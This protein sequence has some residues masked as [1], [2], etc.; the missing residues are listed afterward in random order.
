NGD[1]PIPVPEDLLFPQVDK[2]DPSVR[3]AVPG[4]QNEIINIQERGIWHTLQAKMAPLPQTAFEIA[5]NKDYLNRAVRQGPVDQQIAQSLRYAL[6]E[7]QPLSLQQF[8]KEGAI[9]LTGIRKAP[10][11]VTKPRAEPKRK[12]SERSK[13]PEMPESTQTIEDWLNK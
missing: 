5:M 4:Y 9:G 7:Q 8:G 10:S 6:S 3:I 1:T 12:L 13:L 2:N 11:F